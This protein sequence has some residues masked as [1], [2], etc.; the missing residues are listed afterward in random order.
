MSIRKSILILA[1]GGL[2]GGLG[3]L[4]LMP[5]VGSD[6]PALVQEVAGLARGRA[7]A[8]RQPV[9][10]VARRLEA[11]REARNETDPAALAAALEDAVRWPDSAA[12]DLEIDALLGQLA[13]LAP[14]YSAAIAVAYGLDARFV[15]DAWLSWAEFDAQAALDGLGRIGHPMTRRRVALALTEAFG[16]DAR[17]LER[18]AAALSTTEGNLLWIDWIEQRARSDPF[19]AYREALARND[20]GLSE[21]ALLRVATAWAGQDPQGALAQADL[22]P[23]QFASGFRTAV[24][25][26][27]VRSD[28]DGFAN[29]FESGAA[30]IDQALAGVSYLLAV[31]PARAERLADSVQSPLSDSLRA[32]AIAALARDDVESAKARASVAPPGPQRDLMVQGVATA[33]AEGDP[34]AAIEWLKGLSP[35]VPNAMRSVALSLI[36]TD[37]ARALDLLTENSLGMEST[38]ALSMLVSAG[39]QDPETIPDIAEH[40]LDRGDAQS[41]AALRNLV[42]GWMQRDPET[43]LDW[44]LSRRASVDPAVLAGAAQTLAARDPVNAAAY[45]DRLP[46]DLQPSWIMQVA[47]QYGRYDPNGAM[48]WIVRYQGRDYYD[49]ALRQM[50]TGM[51][52]TD[53]RSAAGL[54]AQASPAVRSAVAVQVASSWAAEDPWAAARWAERL[55]EPDARQGAMTGVVLRW[56]DSDPRSARLWVMEQRSG[57]ER[58]SA[59]TVLM[60]SSARRGAFEPE[61]LD[62]FSSAPQRQLALTN[63]LTAMAR[64]YPDEAR[65]IMERE[66]TDLNQRAL[67]EARIEQATR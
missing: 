15:A 49:I 50:I 59:L 21:R 66:V 19:G 65:A 33:L 67:I 6:A 40:L 42:S 3:T 8:G 56:A 39:A 22:M 12:R 61:V 45:V 2:L 54:L 14:D 29:Y 10:D 57:A 23:E 11:Y 58:D 34:D 62:A 48:A 31:D 55:V 4:L 30:P 20:R 64:Q 47:N 32:A 7:S 13:G 41:N 53:P 44:V 60:T 17:A 25:T 36:Q 38:L 51:S 43:A 26:E 35:P 52:Q 46:E 5:G 24:Y 9:V 16:D 18:T 63:A 1:V 28:A 37:P 27:W